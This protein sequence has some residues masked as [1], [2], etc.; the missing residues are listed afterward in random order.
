MSVPI[1]DFAIANE[2]E[3]LET[4]DTESYYSCCGKSTCGGCVHSFCKSGN[5]SNSKCPFCN[6]DIMSK[7]DLDRVEEMMKYGL[8]WE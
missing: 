5:A 8:K 3:T 4:I 6:S 2:N 1:H 7:T